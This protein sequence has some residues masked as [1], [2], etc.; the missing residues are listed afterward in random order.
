MNRQEL[1]WTAEVSTIKI[2]DVSSQRVNKVF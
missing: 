1:R 2:H